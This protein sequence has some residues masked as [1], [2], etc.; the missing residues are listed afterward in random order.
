M[1]KPLERALRAAQRPNGGWPAGPGGPVSTEATALAVMALERRAPAV[2]SR[3]TGWLLEHQRPDGAWSSMEGVA[4]PGWTTSLAA[5]ALTRSHPEAARM[6]ATW[7]M[8][9]RGRTFP[10]W[11]KLF[12]WLFPGRAVVELDPA[13]RGWAWL[14]GTFSWVEP[15]A[16]AILAL[17]A[18]RPGS[19]ERV[20]RHVDEAERMLLDRVCADGGWNY[21]NS[22]VLGE[23]LWPYP[24]TTA[25]ALLALVDRERVDAVRRSLDTLG[26]MMADTDSG[27]SLA[28]S[29]LC[30]DAFAIDAVALRDR[31]RARTD[32]IVRHGDTRSVALGLVALDR[33]SDRFVRPAAIRRA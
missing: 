9:H 24:D 21:G 4:L 6:G 14:P 8:E 1:G 32:G 17:R 33:R 31:L 3:G 13:L 27:L 5:L 28:L 11:T 22:R 25:I 23:E 2:A 30:F 19:P 18:L 29:I 7:L 10:W 15:T 12:M 26:R 20:A 16:Y